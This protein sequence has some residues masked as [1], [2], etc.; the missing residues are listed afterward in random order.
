MENLIINFGKKKI[1]LKAKEC[2]GIMKF[3][4]LM[5]SNQ[6]KDQILIF[7]FNKITKT[8][9]H[10]YFCPKFLAVW[11]KNNKVIEYKLII[12][13][14]LSISPKYPFDTLIEIPVNKFNQSLINK[15]ITVDRKI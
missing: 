9:I 10:S 3:I 4:G 7:K 6:E 15:F 13:R 8:P 5:F 11:T 2:K 12:K 1:V 14:K